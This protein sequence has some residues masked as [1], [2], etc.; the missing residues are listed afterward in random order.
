[1]NRTDIKDEAAAASE[2]SAIIAAEARAVL[3]ARD[4]D[5]FRAA[6]GCDPAIP[7]RTL[8]TCGLRALGDA[9]VTE[10]F[11]KVRDFADFNEGDDPYGEHDF[12]AF[13]VKGERVFF[14]VDYYAD[15]DCEEGAEDP[16]DIAGTY[17][18]LTIMT[19]A[20]Y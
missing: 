7:G 14:K 9:A 11:A 12:G 15:A 20:E 8:F 19:A 1:M 2:A 13:D 10:A 18:V 6:M 16:S 17:R 4:N 3:I 5:R